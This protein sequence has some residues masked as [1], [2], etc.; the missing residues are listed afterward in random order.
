MNLTKQLG[1]VWAVLAG[2]LLLAAQCSPTAIPPPPTPPLPAP[3]AGPEVRVALL[4]PTTGELAPFGRMMRNGATMAFE[5]RN[6]QGDVLGHRLEWI[7]YDTGCEFEAGG[8]AAQQAIAE[9]VQFI[10][11]P[12]CSEAALA[13]VRPVDA[14]GVVMI[15]P[16]A[17]HPLVTV[18]SQGR[19]RP[20]I[21]R[22]A[23]AYDWQ[24][25]A[26]A[27]FARQS[28]QADTAALVVN[29]RDDYSRT[30][31]RAF[32]EQFSA[33]GGEIAAEIVYD[34]G[35]PEFAA[36]VASLGRFGAEVVYLPASPEIAN[37]LAIRLAES[38]L[39]ESVT[40]LG[41]DSWAG[42]PLD[43]AAVEGSYVT[44]HFEVNEPRPIV[45]T[46]AEAYQAD[47]AIEP[48]TLAALGYDAA[49]MLVEAME[50]AGTLDPDAVAARL[51]EIEFMGVTGP[52]RFNQ[53][54]NP[55]KPVP[56]VRLNEGDMEFITSVE[57]EPVS[58]DCRTLPGD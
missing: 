39:G 58:L 49:S 41:S 28:I 7:T 8:Q 44:T 2:L 17:T 52:I 53:A 3:P 34:P 20:T 26:A 21:F 13:A 40:L 6:R 32:A 4:S 1:Y 33:H 38:G 18:D 43:R 37:R 31:T 24:A 10:I 47:Y 50:K 36:I 22:A 12:L 5:Q 15:S 51:E 9:G 45:Q 11:G 35:E 27:C 42:E 56:V 54:H 30:L 19:T 55:L 14:A 25:R 57:L 48:D 46:W 29:L 16:T 23:Y